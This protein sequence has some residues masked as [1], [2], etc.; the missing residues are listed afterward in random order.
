MLLQSGL[1]SRCHQQAITC[2]PKITILWC[3]HHHSATA[4]PDRKRGRSGRVSCTLLD[5]EMVK[6]CRLSGMPT[7]EGVT[8][9]SS[10]A[11]NPAAK[12]QCNQ[13]HQTGTC[14]GTCLHSC[15][16]G[17]TTLPICSLS[18]Q[19][20]S[21]LPRPDK[22][23]LLEWFTTPVN[24]E[25]DLHCPGVSSLLMELDT[26]KVRAV[27]PAGG[28]FSD[29][30][31]MMHHM[32]PASD[33][34]ARFSSGNL[35]FL[36]SDLGHGMHQHHHTSAVS[37]PQYHHQQQQHQPPPANR[38]NSAER[39]FTSFSRP[40]AAPSHGHPAPTTI[41]SHTSNIPSPHP[42]APGVGPSTTGRDIAAHSQAL[43]AHH[44]ANSSQVA[45]LGVMGRPSQSH[46]AST[47]G[48]SSAGGVSATAGSNSR[49]LTPK[50]LLPPMHEIERLL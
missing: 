11:D 37:V 9:V 7:A 41:T 3:R 12:L 18:G 38:P 46:S 39:L 19:V 14:A 23:V 17:T 27:G 6:R 24:M 34:F 45:G 47:Q 1:S 28:A 50:G 48:T 42:A 26:P 2:C 49:P 15:F 4:H 22:H 21:M 8:H 25:C 10:T 40:T 31:C 30:D 43:A 5:T 20:L 29:F 36:G 13:L 16:P 35:G 33:A 44:A 32:A